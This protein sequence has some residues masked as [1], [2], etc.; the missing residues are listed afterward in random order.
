MLSGYVEHEV[1]EAAHLSEVLARSVQ[2][3]ATESFE[4]GELDE[5]DIVRMY[6]DALAGL[7]IRLPDDLVREIA[8][9]EHRNMSSRM[10][11]S[12]AN[13]GVLQ[14]LRTAGYRLGIVSNAHFLPEMMW[15]DI[16]RLGIADS[17]DSVV[18]SSEIGV[19]KPH[20]AIFRR[21]L[22]KLGMPPEEAMFVGDRLRDDIAGANRLGMVSVLTREFR[23]EDVTPETAQP[24]YVIQ[25]LPELLGVLGVE[26]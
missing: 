18:F 2:R 10:A 26:R 24:D 23:Q 13:L 25:R 16:R 11:I 21:V 19:R 15:E 5:L 8:A 7:G 9:L 4:R 14:S 22:D 12:E 20:P 3:S 6:A 17:V 1:P